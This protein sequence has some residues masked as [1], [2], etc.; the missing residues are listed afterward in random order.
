MQVLRWP[1]RPPLKLP[2]ALAHQERALDE[3]A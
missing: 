1:V 2:E 3:V